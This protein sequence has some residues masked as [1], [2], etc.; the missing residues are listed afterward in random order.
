ME[1]TLILK[2]IQSEYTHQEPVASL[3]WIPS[4]STDVSSRDNQ[5]NVK[6]KKI[7]IKKKKK[8]K[9]KKKLLK[10]KKKKKIL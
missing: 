10:K 9:I 8:K 1:D 6:K 2:S 3:S 7:Q 5:Y 4:S